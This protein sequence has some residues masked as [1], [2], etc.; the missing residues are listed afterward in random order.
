[1]NRPAHVDTIVSQ[2]TIHILVVDDEPDLEPLIR[3][4]FK[5]EIQSGK[6]EFSFA[7]D[8]IE[9]LN[10]IKRDL[11]IDLVL[12]DLSMPNMDGLSLLSN[13]IELDRVL[14]TVV[15]TAYGDMENIRKAMNRGAFDFLLKPLS[16][17]DLK[18]TVSKAGVALQLQKK[19][20]LVRQ[21]FGRY[22]SDEVA[23][24]LLDQP[25]IPVLEGEKRRITLLMSDLRGFAMTAKN[26]GPEEVLEVLN[27]Y[28]GS[29]EEVI[30]EYQ[31]TI[32]DFIGDAILAIFGAPFQRNDDASRA[33]ACA[34]SMQCSMNDVN[35]SVSRL[36][37]PR[38]EMG[39]GIHTGEVVVGNIG[40]IRRMKYG[41]V[42]NHVNLTSQIE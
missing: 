26:L 35:S 38:L 41:A 27:I 40:S 1:M 34:I 10:L 11:L 19:A 18:T 3:Q 14:K 25:G 36:G 9:A 17:E 30:T 15:V 42:G 29:M 23:T 32:V 37:L 22:V 21:T 12:T 24:F 39:I 16:M 8:G 20:E 2:S 31:G 6:Y 33:V 28:L 5:L 4:G 13:L 7:G